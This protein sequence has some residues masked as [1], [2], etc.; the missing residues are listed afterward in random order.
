MVLSSWQVL[1]DDPDLQFITNTS[2]CMRNLVTV[3]STNSFPLSWYWG[4]RNRSQIITATATGKTDSVLYIPAKVVKCQVDNFT[5]SCLYHPWHRVTPTTG[6]LCQ[7]VCYVPGGFRQK[8]FV[9]S[10]LATSGYHWNIRKWSIEIKPK[11][12]KNNNK[13]HSYFLSQ[14]M[15]LRH[16]RSVTSICRE[17]F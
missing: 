10:S 6:F 16:H 11:N 1:S 17:R 9:N 12:K 4:F 5:G 3:F 14:M 7:Y 13:L 8:E 15:S 2:V